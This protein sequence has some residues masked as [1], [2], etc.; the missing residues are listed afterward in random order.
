MQKYGTP[1]RDETKTKFGD[2][3]HD[4]LWT[5]PS[6]SILLE[7]GKVSVDVD[8]MATDKKALDVL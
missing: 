2:L 4:V 5:F 8:Y 7:L 6:T 3:M 1:A